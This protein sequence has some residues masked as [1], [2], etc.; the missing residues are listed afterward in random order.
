[1]KVKKEQKAQVYTT[2]HILILLA[3]SLL[4][5]HTKNL[6]ADRAE[7]V[8]N[9]VISWEL[10]TIEHVPEIE[11][12]EV[13]FDDPIES[14]IYD[15]FGARGAEVTATFK[16]EN[17]YQLRNGWD[18]KHLTDNTNGTQDIGIAKI[19]SIHWDRCGGKE[20]LENPYNNID[21]AFILYNER[22]EWGMDGLTAWYSYLNNKHL[23]FMLL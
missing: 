18:S 15:K 16:H 2:A 11:P 23:M 1:M 14:Y 22:E 9:P 21:C 17:G 3:L 8:L 10:D 5:T 20:A 13:A 7:A 12:T 4:N 19:N 6:S